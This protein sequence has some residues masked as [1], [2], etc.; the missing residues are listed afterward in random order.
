[1]K[2]KFIFGIEFVNIVLD[3]RKRYSLLQ[4]CFAHSVQNEI[5]IF[6]YS[7]NKVEMYK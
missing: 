7:D 4:A 2:L 6:T 3:I 5:E 1:M